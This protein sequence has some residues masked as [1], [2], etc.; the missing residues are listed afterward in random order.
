MGKSGTHLRDVLD[1]FLFM[2][3]TAFR[4][5]V[6]VFKTGSP[7]MEM[8]QSLQVLK[9]RYKRPND[10]GKALAC[11]VKGFEI[12][13]NDFLGNFY[14]AI[15]A[16]NEKTGQFFTPCSLSETIA[17][18]T[19]TREHYEATIAQGKRFSI[20]EPAVGAGGMII[21]VAKLMREWDAHPTTWYVDCTDVDIR[22]VR[23]AYIQFTLLG[24]PAYI[25]HGNSLTLEQWD[26]WPT[27]TM[28]MNPLAPPI[29][30]ESALTRLRE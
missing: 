15:D 12:E 11:M 28:Q 1:D 17:R 10:F 2:A 24:I 20:S 22:C 25:R 30:I 6:H 8:E 18:M 29:K 26:V 21:Q 19:L 13:A 3:S 16:H 27:L 4:Q 5:A 23:M 14:G 9:S 7:D